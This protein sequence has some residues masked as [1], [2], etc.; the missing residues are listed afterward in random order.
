MSDATTL[1]VY[2]YATARYA[3]KPDFFISTSNELPAENFGPIV[4]SAPFLF[5]LPADFNLTAIEVAE[6]QAQKVAALEDYQRSVANIN[7]RLAK[8]QALTCEVAA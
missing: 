8:L 1:T 2:V 3:G 5:T 4:A 6:L 7:E